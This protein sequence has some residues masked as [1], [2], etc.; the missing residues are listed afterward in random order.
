M[1]DLSI[2]RFLGCDG[3]QLGYRE[4]GKCCAL[5]LVHGYFS[6]ATGTWFPWSCCQD[7]GV[8]PSVR[9]A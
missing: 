8:L 5:V 2:R 9:H 7:R 1:I 4:T 6:T 3:A